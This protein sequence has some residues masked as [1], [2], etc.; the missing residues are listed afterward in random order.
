MVTLGVFVA[1]SS[2]V[3]ADEP[4]ERGVSTADK[5]AARRLTDEGF[6]AARTASWPVAADK[7]RQALEHWDHPK[8]HLN[9][10]HAL[11]MIDKP[12][13]AQEHVT[14]ALAYGER[15]LTAQQ[16][17]DAL[18]QQ[19]QL[20]ARIATLT[21]Q[22]DA[23][24][25]AVTLDGAQLFVGP[26]EA[27]VKLLPGP[28][29]LVASKDG[30]FAATRSVVL[31]GGTSTV[32]A[33]ALVELSAGRTVY[34]RRFRR[35]VPWVVVAA[36]AAAGA[37]GLGLDR[38]AQSSYD[39]Y[40]DLIAQHCDPMCPEAEAERYA[41]F[42]DQGHNLETGA[43][44]SYSLGGALLVTG[45]VMAI[46]NRPRVVRVEAPTIQPTASPAGAGAT[47]TWTF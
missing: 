37:T 29:Q 34:A 15:G 28:H 33:L 18:L 25:A 17:R 22:C 43:V 7:F 47:A 21:V 39:R 6:E 16:Y 23:P 24:G 1:A 14:A 30:Y 10:V 45:V 32:E 4:W 20:A 2:P 12:L 31:I 8:I 11:I 36:S 9:L 26:G 35:W 19:K 3:A 5:D 41:A 42:Y 46:I 27:T 13:E 40:D 44:V 38:R